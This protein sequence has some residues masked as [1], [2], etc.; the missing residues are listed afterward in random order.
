MIAEGSKWPFIADIIFLRC[1]VLDKITVFFVDTVIG[2][3]LE[4]VVFCVIRVAFWGK[5]CQSFL[6]NVDS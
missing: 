4:L 5:S 3:M 6:I 2:Q 1:L